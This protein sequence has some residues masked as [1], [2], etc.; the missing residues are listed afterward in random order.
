VVKI[1]GNR[2]VDHCDMEKALI[3]IR[4]YDEATDA[5]TVGI[6]IADT[7]SEYNLSFVLPSERGAY[8]GPFQYARS[9]E[10][11]H[12]ALI[13][14]MINAP[15]VYLAENEQG[16]LV[17]VLRGS[18]E[19][20]HSLFVRGDHHR[21]GIGRMLVNHFEQTCL[22]VGG[23]VV[24]LASSLHAVPFYQSMGYKKSTGVRKGWSFDGE[25]FLWQPMKKVLEK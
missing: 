21:Q 24:R 13:A 22:I 4:N 15:M 18:N 2:F 19:R 3:K 17:G 25:G 6:L 16:K 1:A 7:Y 8:L 20:L 9:Q 12:R 5:A 14:R 11:E 10:A 23:R